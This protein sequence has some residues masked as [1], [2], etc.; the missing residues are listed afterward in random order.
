MEDKMRYSEIA[1]KVKKAEMILIGIG[2]EFRPKIPE[3]KL[4]GRALPY[5]VSAYYHSLADTDKV[6]GA[7]KRLRE[8]AGAKPYFVVTLN[9]DDLVYRGGFERDLVVAPCGSM[10]S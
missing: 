5:A 2:E 4:D 3:M 9:T 1:E 10:E 8:L 7:Y 6:I